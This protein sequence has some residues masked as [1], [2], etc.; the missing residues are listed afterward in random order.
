MPPVSVLGKT[1]T[2]PHVKLQTANVPPNPGNAERQ[3]TP[4]NTASE[5]E[6]DIFFR[7]REEE[8]VGAD[9]EIDDT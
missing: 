7:R 2:D 8:K 1:G 4:P 6:D 3:S 9:L 5:D